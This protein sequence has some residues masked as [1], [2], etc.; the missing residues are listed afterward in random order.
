MVFCQRCDDYRQV[1]MAPKDYVVNCVSCK[2]WA[3][4]EY[5]TAFVT[6]ETRA[7]THAAK[8]PG[9]RVRLIEGDRIVR[10]WFY[11]P[12]M[13]EADAPPF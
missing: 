4:R 12:L 13:I 8:N 10:E 2:R 11:A 3:W 1:G 5:G 9:H 7:I 6:A